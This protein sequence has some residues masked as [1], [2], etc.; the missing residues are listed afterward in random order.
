VSIRVLSGC[1]ILMIYMLCTGSTEVQ[2]RELYPPYQAASTASS[3]DTAP[4]ER[5]Y[6]I[7]IDT[8]NPVL[9]VYLHGKLYR[10]YPIALGKDSTETPIGSWTIVDKQTGWGNGFGTR[11]LGLNVPWGT[12][13]IH[14][15]NRPESIGNY[16]SNG[17]IRMQNAD[18]EQ[19]YNVLPVGTLV[20]I[21]GNPIRFHRTLK[22]GNIGADVRWVQEKLQQAGYFRGACDGRF[23]QSTQ[24]ALIYF[25]LSRGIPMDGVVGADDYRA[26]SSLFQ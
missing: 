1:V 20:V 4:A 19:L 3:E 9:K 5:T 14:G 6:L 24:F 17:C 15:T 8:S 18:V 25:E 2:A 7:R 10:T 12:Y 23:Q 21:T 13:G 16:A 22:Y 26:L 11:W